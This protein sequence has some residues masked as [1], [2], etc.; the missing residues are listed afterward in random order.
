MP[1]SFSLS[2]IMLLAGLA[3]CAD[4]STS[5]TAPDH[6]GIA[7][8]KPGGPTDP[9]ATWTLPAPDGVIGFASDGQGAYADGACG[10]TTRIFATT[11]GSNSGDAT[12]QVAKA[13]NCT[14][15]FTLRYPDGSTET[16]PSFNN[17]LRLQNTSSSIPIGTTVKR[18]LIVSPGAI[19][20][21][22]SR[23]GRLLFG[24][25]GTVGAGSDSLDVTRVDA[26]TWQVQSAGSNNLATCENTG[27]LYAMPVSFTVTSSYPLP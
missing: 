12:I 5:P 17:L 23:C 20:N 14:R 11:A 15:R 16:I 10:V 1:R 8:A 6:T 4:Q 18:R 7:M 27:E 19:T 9:T 21:N 26:S 13:K 3:A 2:L 24:P 25:N 22:P